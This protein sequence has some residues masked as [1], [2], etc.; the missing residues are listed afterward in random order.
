MHMDP[1]IV[2]ENADQPH[3]IKIQRPDI[4]L[5]TDKMSGAQLLLD[6]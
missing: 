2:T 5:K 6:S 4:S 1:V 3:F